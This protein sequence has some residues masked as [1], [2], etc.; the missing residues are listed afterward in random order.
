MSGGCS[1]FVHHDSF[2]HHNS[3]QNHFPIFQ[4]QARLVNPATRARFVDEPLLRPVHYSLDRRE[5]DAAAGHLPFGGSVVALA[6][7]DPLG[8]GGDPPQLFLVVDGLRPARG[9][10]F[11]E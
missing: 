7:G 8:Q 3:Q 10:D 9:D 1:F 4:L 11:V 6:C 2:G 5:R